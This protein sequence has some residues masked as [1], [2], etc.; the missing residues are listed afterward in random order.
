M[1]PDFVFFGESIS[2]KVKDHRCAEEARYIIVML[3]NR[4]HSIVENADR[5]F[6]LGTTVATYSAFRCVPLALSAHIRNLKMRS[7]A[8]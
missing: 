5:L 4:S 1:K 8:Y 7:I 2:K 3:T 6:I